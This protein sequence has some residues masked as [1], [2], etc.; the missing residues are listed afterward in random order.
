MRMYFEDVVF[1]SGGGL[2]GGRVA[3]AAR[4][5]LDVRRKVRSVDGCMVWFGKIWPADLFGG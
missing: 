2:R 3:A 5:V 1:L 4:E